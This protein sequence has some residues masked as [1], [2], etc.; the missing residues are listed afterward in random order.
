VNRKRR[1]VEPPVASEENTL[2]NGKSDLGNKLEALM[3][4]KQLFRNKD[5]RIADVATELCTNT[6]YL[7]TC[8]NGELNTTFPAFVTNYRIRFAQELMR[9]NPTMRLS[10]VAEESGFANE[11]TFLRSFKAICG[12]TPSEWKEQG[13]E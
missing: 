9:E 5:L 7:S 13:E 11:K 8:L 10:Q 12:V 3:E 6:T 4:E 1:Q 2:S